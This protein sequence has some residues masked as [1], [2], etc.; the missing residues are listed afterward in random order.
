[1]YKRINNTQKD[2]Q[3]CSYYG[4][5]QWPCG[6]GRRSAATSLLRSRVRSRW[7]HD[8]S[9]CVFI[10]C[11]VGSGLCDELITRSEESCRVCDQEMS[12]SVRPRPGLGCCAAE[13]KIHIMIY[14]VMTPCRVPA[15]G[16]P[17]RMTHCWRHRGLCEPS[18]ES[19]SLYITGVKHTV[20]IR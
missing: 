7:G 17:F 3:H 16:P 9:S 18:W 15:G 14:R 13:I 20:R 6:L 8:C 10:V 1:M 19:V 11:C 2:K 12:T 4:R 5:S